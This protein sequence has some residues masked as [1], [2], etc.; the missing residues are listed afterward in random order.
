MKRLISLLLVLSLLCIPMTGCGKNKKVAICVPESTSLD[1]G[2]LISK[3]EEQG[4]SVSLFVEKNDQ[5]AQIQQIESLFKDGY[6][7]L[8]IEPMIL[9]AVTDIMNH[10]Q[11]KNMPILFVNHYGTPP[12]A[13]GKTA[14]LT[15]D[16]A[17]LGHTQ[18]LAFDQLPDGGDVN[19]DGMISYG[20][21][22]GLVDDNFVYDQILTITDEL[23]GEL[24]EVRHCDNL[25]EG[26]EKACN[27]LLA[28]YGRDLEV[29]I[30]TDSS[31]TQ[32]A[33]ATIANN[34]RMP[35]QNLYVVGAGE[36]PDILQLLEA[37]TLNVTAAPKRTDNGNQIV[38]L[39]IDMLSGNDFSANNIYNYQVLIK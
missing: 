7:L 32:T 11:R 4:Y 35:G 19:G 18:V 29:L 24:L 39:A 20:V 25:S 27:G 23:N 36:S 6:H 1:T 3:L 15:H 21:L 17:A 8:I 9:S 5:N 26:P 14:F 2:Y 33:V 34:G 16:S 31:L 22:A 30:C 12:E 38:T 10:P 37:G 13:S 28:A